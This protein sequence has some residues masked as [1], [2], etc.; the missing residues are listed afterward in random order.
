MSFNSVLAHSPLGQ[1]SIGFMF[2]ISFDLISPEAMRSISFD[3]AD[4]KLKDIL[5]TL[6]K[7]DKTFPGIYDY[8]KKV[9]DW[10]YGATPE[11]NKPTPDPVVVPPNEE[12]KPPVIDPNAPP[13]QPPQAAPGAPG[14]DDGFKMDATQLKN[15]KLFLSQF[16]FGY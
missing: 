5:D 1:S 13:Q 8:V 3:P 2:A 10:L 11:S 7:Y 14:A 12:P 6:I 9:R 16:F 4:F 15:V